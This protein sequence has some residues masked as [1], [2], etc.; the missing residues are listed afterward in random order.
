MADVA[1]C[2]VCR[3]TLVQSSAT[4]VGIGAARKLLHPACF[5]KFKQDKLTDAAAGAG[6]EAG[7][8]LPGVAP[9]KRAGARMSVATAGAMLPR[10]SQDSL[11]FV[12]ATGVWSG[13]SAGGGYSAPTFANNPQFVLQAL[14]PCTVEVMLEQTHTGPL[15][16]V[17]VQICDRDG[18]LVSRVKQRDILQ[19]TLQ[20]AQ[21]S[22][23]ER[24]AWTI[25]N[26]PLR[27]VD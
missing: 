26:C 25:A 9:G 13:N 15:V 7:L 18:A 12:T 3:K 17:G 23:S 1:V 5:E 6:H 21:K 27:D 19:N 20:R 22:T 8:P 11:D 24:Q 14:A 4:A 10:T 2:P 16:P